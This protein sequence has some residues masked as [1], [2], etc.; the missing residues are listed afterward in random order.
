MLRQLKVYEEVLG[1]KL[2]LFHLLYGFIQ[3]RQFYQGEEE[4]LYLDS[5]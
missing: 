5:K 2:F 1:L 4:A 3:V